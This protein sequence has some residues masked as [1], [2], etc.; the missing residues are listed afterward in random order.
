MPL[1][2]SFLSSLEDW[3]LGRRLREW[4]FL[5]LEKRRPWGDLIAAFLYYEEVIEMMEPGS[6]YWCI[7]GG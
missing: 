4:A 7:V 3:K 6:S 1:G 5:T 2:V